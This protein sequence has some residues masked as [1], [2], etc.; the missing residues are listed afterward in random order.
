MARTLDEL[1]HYLEGLDDRADLAD[2][3]IEMSQLQ[4]R[5]DELADFVRF[6]SN[7]YARN[8]IRSGPW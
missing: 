2:L 8:L 6:S 3:L 7:G 1:F 5:F 4:V